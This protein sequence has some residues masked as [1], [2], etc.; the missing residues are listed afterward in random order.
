[1]EIHPEDIFKT[2]ESPL[3]RFYNTFQSE[4]T[5]HDYDRKLKK[6][7]CEFLATILVGDPNLVNS[8][9]HSPKNQLK[10]PHSNFQLLIIKLE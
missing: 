9:L 8:E 1:M 7:M 2:D 10:S 4:Q 3:T 5:K 6:V